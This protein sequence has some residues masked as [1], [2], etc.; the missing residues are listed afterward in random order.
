MTCYDHI[1]RLAARDKYEPIRDAGEALQ[2]ALLADDAPP[3]HDPSFPRGIAGAVHG[4]WEALRAALSKSDLREIVQGWQPGEN[5][6]YDAKCLVMMQEDASEHWVLMQLGS[7]HSVRTLHRAGWTMFRRAVDGFLAALLGALNPDGREPP[8]EST[9]DEEDIAILLVLEH[10]APRRLTQV[11]I[12]T[13][14]TGPKVRAA[15][16]DLKVRKRPTLRTIADRL[17]GL[18]TAGFVCYPKGPK[19][20]AAITRAGLELLSRCK[21]G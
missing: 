16:T 12:D 18:V 14:M 21:A 3:W 9:V 6:E 15:M 10:K 5:A 1:Q 13:A 20:G 19:Q 17:P 8:A 7:A 2:R 4:L 11:Q